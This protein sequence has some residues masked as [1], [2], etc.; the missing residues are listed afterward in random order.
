MIQNKLYSPS[1][2]NIEDRGSISKKSIRKHLNTILDVL[3][4]L[5]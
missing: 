3:Y 5:N 4:C 1:L 2:L